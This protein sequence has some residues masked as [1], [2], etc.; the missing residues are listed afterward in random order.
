MAMQ[1]RAQT[2][3]G[4]RAFAGTLFLLVGAFNFIGGIVAVANPHYYVVTS[5]GNGHQLVFGDLTSWGWTI[6]ILGALQAIV[7]LAIFAARPWAAVVGIVF[8]VLDA[9][10]QLLYLGEDPWWS[11][12]VLGIDVLVIFA[13]TRYGFSAE[14]A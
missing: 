4:W 7:A 13:L 11:I 5:L 1:Q 9:I 8:A 2:G 10:A 6:L 3:T 12:I 14:E